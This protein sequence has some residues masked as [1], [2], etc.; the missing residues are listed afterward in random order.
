LGR[1]LGEQRR[2][3][4]AQAT[5][6]TRC[7]ARL[8]S[9]KARSIGLLQLNLPRMA[10]VSGLQ[11]RSLRVARHPG[12]NRAGVAARVIMRWSHADR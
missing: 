9:E 3:V 11:A 2:S 8:A 6:I 1:F 4:A 12:D 5:K 7:D 10:P